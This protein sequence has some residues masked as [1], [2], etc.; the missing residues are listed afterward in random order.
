MA[1]YSSRYFEDDLAA[2][3]PTPYGRGAYDSAPS[4]G[5]VAYTSYGCF[6]NAIP[7]YAGYSPYGCSSIAYSASTFSQPQFIEYDPSPCGSDH[8]TASTQF[9]ISY[10]AAEFNLPEFK[11]YNPAPYSG[12]YDLAETYGKPLPPSDEICYPRSVPDLKAPSLDG[13]AFG[14]TPL[15]SEK[16]ETQGQAA[17]PQNGREQSPQKEEERQL[18]GSTDQGHESDEE[19]TYQGE[20][21]TE[22]PADDSYPWS[23]YGFGTAEEHGDQYGKSVP[24]PPSGYGLEAMDLCESLFGYW[25]CLSHEKRRGARQECAD[26]KESNSDL[27]KGS[28]DYLFGSSCPYGENSRDV[29]GSYGIPNYSYERH[30][31]ELPLYMQ[32]D[33]DEGSWLN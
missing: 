13:V 3:S 29:G 2:Y 27:W 6:N 30:Y 9:V 8:N 20:R 19:E 21:R 12:G 32:I 31:Q 28:A 1:Y 14:S 26:N 16:D 24:L 15:P 18:Q 25:P 7:Y 33:Y 11:E 17:K 5:L 10:S 23:G 22:D 4:H